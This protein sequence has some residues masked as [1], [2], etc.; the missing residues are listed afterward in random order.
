MKTQ[1]KAAPR[2]RGAEGGDGVWHEI[3]PRCERRGSGVGQ[4]C[5]RGVR[6]RRPMRAHGL[7]YPTA[8]R[9]TVCA[10]PGLEIWG[11]SITFGVLPIATHPAPCFVLEG[12]MPASWLCIGTIGIWVLSASAVP[13]LLHSWGHVIRINGL[14]IPHVLAGREGAAPA[15]GLGGK[16]GKSGGKQGKFGGNW[17]FTGQRGQSKAAA[18]GAAPPRALGWVFWGTHGANGAQWDAVENHHVCP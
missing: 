16:W 18:H 15:G 10:P 7:C 14:H 11:K 6:C 17:G 9:C 2:Y 1:R 4:S 13:F 3:W 5:G 12:E 8:G